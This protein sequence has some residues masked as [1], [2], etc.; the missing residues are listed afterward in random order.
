V[1]DKLFHLPGEPAGVI[2]NRR[3]DTHMSFFEATMLICFGISWPISIAKS[4]RTRTV[5]GKSPRFMAIVCIGY[6]SGCIH[7]LLYSL[8]WILI[9]YAANM[10]MVA[11]DLVL[12]FKFLP[13]EPAPVPVPTDEELGP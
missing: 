10:V 7:K 5:I 4:L 13:K 11:I 1:A 3:K 8:D 12:Y 9:L 2:E 6:M